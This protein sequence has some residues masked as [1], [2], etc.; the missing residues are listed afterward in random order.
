VLHDQ[1]HHGLP[2][3]LILRFIADRLLN[4]HVRRHLI[5]PLAWRAVGASYAFVFR[6]SVARE[7]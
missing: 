3:L 5:L 2:V 7:S 6:S 1:G 4:D